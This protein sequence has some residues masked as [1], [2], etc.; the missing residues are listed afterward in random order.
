MNKVVSLLL[1]IIS[2]NLS[3]FCNDVNLANEA[4]SKGDYTKACNLGYQDGCDRYTELS[5]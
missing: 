4:Y 3:L 2:F 5:K 1:W